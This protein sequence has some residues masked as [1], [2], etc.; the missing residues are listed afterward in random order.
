MSVRNQIR[1]VTDCSRQDHSR[2]E[3]DTCCVFGGARALTAPFLRVSGPPRR[4]QGITCYRFV[5][6]RLGSGRLLMRSQNHALFISAINSLLL[7]L[8]LRLRKL[9]QQPFTTLYSELSHRINGVI[10]WH[11]SQTSYMVIRGERLRI[12]AYALEKW[13]VQARYLYSLK[14]KKI[15]TNADC[16]SRIYATIRAQA[17]QRAKDS[18]IAGMNNRTR[19]RADKGKSATASDEVDT[20]KRERYRAMETVR[21]YQW[22]AI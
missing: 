9:V 15:N 1:V 13:I 22:R 2:G 11:R 12:Q 10:K 3:I 8:R 6:T 16:L 14:A 17:R 19:K 4:H 7:L 5:T 21:A 18:A 20:T